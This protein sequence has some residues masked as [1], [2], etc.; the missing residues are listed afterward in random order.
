MIDDV[1]G[2]HA[3]ETR[4]VCDASLKSAFVYEGA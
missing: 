3:V 2:F 1:K 4:S